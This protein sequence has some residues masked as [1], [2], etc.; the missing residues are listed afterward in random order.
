MP[1]TEKR[2]PLSDSPDREV[3]PE[4]S[5]QRL[6]S[7]ADLLD[8][9]ETRELVRRYQAGEEDAIHL[10]LLRNQR[11]FRKMGK[12]FKWAF[13][14]TSATIEDLASEGMLGFVK[15]VERFDLTREGIKLSSYAAWW[16]R[17]HIRT[18][19]AN[20]GG[21]I[22]IPEWVR[23]ASFKVDRFRKEFEAENGTR[24]TDEEIVAGIGITKEKLWAV[25]AGR[26]ASR[27]GSYDAVPIKNGETVRMDPPAK[28][29]DSAET[30][31]RN[32]EWSIVALCLQADPA[33]FRISARNLEIFKARIGWDAESGRLSG[34]FVSRVLIARQF[35]VTEERIRQIEG[36]AMK[37]IRFMAR[38]LLSDQCPKNA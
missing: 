15:G 9:A 6:L 13:P 35:G 24:P 11:L 38:K 32:E 4:L 34:R 8:E 31:A 30:A 27:I 18:S 29:G 21:M 12:A 3:D 26:S 33:E 14:H 23:T 22:R 7:E 10:L 20:E 19:I 28:T 16:I 1:R 36:Q 17:S 2:R 5:G 37:R 25:H